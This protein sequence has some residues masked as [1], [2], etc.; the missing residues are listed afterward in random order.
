MR[1]LRR[2]LLRNIRRYRAQ[3]A[4]VTVIVFLGVT[5]FVAAYDSFRN[6]EASYAQTAEDF[7]F[8]NLNVVGRDVAGFAEA[9]V[10]VDGVAAVETRWVADVPIRLHGHKLLGRVVG[11]PAEAQ[12]AV[13]RLL[14]LE[15]GY[16]GGAMEGVLVEEHMAD[17][18]DLRPGDSV[19]VLGGS[20]WTTLEV[21]GVVS[22]PE[23]IWPARS[24]QDLLTTPDDFGVLFAAAEVAGALV[25]GPRN[26]AVVYYD[27]GEADPELTARLSALADEAGAAD[28]FTRSDQPSNLALEEDLKGFS[29]ISVL[30]PVL[31]LVAAAMAAF[32]TINR[33]VYAQRPEIGVLLANGVPRRSVTTHVLGYGLV[34]GIVGA[35]PGVIAGAL[36]ARLITGVYTGLLSVP[37]RLIRFYPSTLVAGLLLGVVATLLAAAGPA[38][39]AARIQPVEAMRELSPAGRGRPSIL[40]RLVPPLRRLPVRW[41][42]VLRGIGRNRRR[43]AYTIIGVVL[44]LT[45]VLVS[46]GMLNTVDHLLDRQFLEIQR[47][48]A[49]V[50][51]VEPVS[52]DDAAEV[53]DLPGIAAAEPALLDLPVAIV[54]GGERYPTTLSAFV[55]ETSMHGFPQPELLEDGLVLGAA[56]RDLLD[57]DVGDRVAVV[58]LAGGEPFS[59]PVAGFVSEPLGSAAYTSLPWLVEAS[60]MRETAVGALLRYEPEVDRAAVRAAVSADPRV[61]AFSDSLALYDTVQRYMSLFY[62]FVGVMLVFGAAMAFALIFNAMSVNIA[63]RSREVAT[64]LAVG[65][66]R[67]T[68]SRLITA[69]N[70]LVAAA[71]IPLGLVLGRFVSAQAMASFESD[72][73]Q[74]DMYMRATTLAGA[75]VAVMVVGLLSLWPGLRAVRRMDVARIVKQRSV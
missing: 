54:G 20:G 14:L 33:M 64:M 27:G 6:L 58:P 61:A 67:R 3:F 29:E 16:L 37:V 74:F 63:E 22:S 30:F 51:F 8:A 73:F 45:L 48:D 36:L 35:I 56:L 11:V 46:W 65:T 42:M 15:G 43:T 70:I 26:E 24:R 2:K 57:V 69:E 60:G 66:D 7:R 23:Y 44:S 34:P 41:R 1:V 55:P 32:V 62:G 9:A 21:A 59:G 50:L 10:V 28:T 47:E 68:I 12:P 31:F 4:A 13:N 19:E 5:M 38:R 52:F 72:L 75:A 39:S 18:F 53:A 71:G 25:G 49:T 40:E 17:H